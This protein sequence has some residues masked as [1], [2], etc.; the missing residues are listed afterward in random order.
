MLDKVG[1][2]EWQCVLY[3]E[4]NYHSDFARFMNWA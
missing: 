1:G 2:A 4:K 3:Y